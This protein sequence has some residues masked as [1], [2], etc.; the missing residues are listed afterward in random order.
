MPD[1]IF[2]SD[3]L[4][5]PVIKA[6]EIFKQSVE[7][8]WG[9]IKVEDYTQ[10][11]GQ[12][13]EPLLEIQKN[14][15]DFVSLTNG[16]ISTI[17]GPF[18][19]TVSKLGQTLDA[20]QEL[21]I[22]SGALFEK[23]NY[24][25][26]NEPV[27]SALNFATDN[28]ALQ[29]KTIIG[30]LGDISKF[31]SESVQK[32]SELTKGSLI[33]NIALE[34]IQES[35]FLFP[36]T[37]AILPEKDLNTERISTLEKEIK[38]LKKGK[39]KTIVSEITSELEGLLNNIDKSDSLV[40]MFRGACAVIGQNDDSLAQSAESMTRLMENFPSYLKKDDKFNGSKKRT[41]PEILAILLSIEYKNIKD[42]KHPLI[43]QQHYFYTTFSQIRHR[44]KEIYK[45]FEEDPA[46]YKA[47]VLQAE[48]FLYQ[49]IKPFSV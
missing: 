46:K 19:D 35:P 41:I 49:I 33:N 5:A 18:Y 47:L 6:G 31:S 3:K 8:Y 15:L 22:K 4:P 37:T 17:V 10:T 29:Q 2:K 44:N 20:V 23:A 7:P 39:T 26:I 42:I 14:I 40:K 36:Q 25:F 11:I 45:S 24:N 12:K 48:G 27:I 21:T 13:I 9:Q 1:D 34:S 32:I 28:I 38:I 30:E 16:K 43:E